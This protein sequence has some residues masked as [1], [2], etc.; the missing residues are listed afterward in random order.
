MNHSQ[1][2][3][4]TQK[5]QHSF[6]PMYFHAENYETLNE[7]AKV[8][9]VAQVFKDCE[10]WFIS[11][12]TTIVHIYS[13]RIIISDA[14]RNLLELSSHDALQ[15]YLQSEEK[16]TRNIYI[17]PKRQNLCISGL[18]GEELL[19]MDS[20]CTGLLT[21]IITGKNYWRAPYYQRSHRNTYR[22][23]LSIYKTW[24]KR[25]CW[26][27]LRNLCWWSFEHWN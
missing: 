16:W 7:K 18:K 1:I 8:H 5:R 3:R 22:R 11:H 19:E 27:H 4:H 14:S 13:T 20:L 26:R 25:N 6:C 15:A 10:T 24:Q 17:F 12:D 9:Y 2:T 23:F 21:E